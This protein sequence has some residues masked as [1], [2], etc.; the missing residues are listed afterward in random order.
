M[1]VAISYLEETTSKNFSLERLV[2]PIE[3]IDLFSLLKP[4]ED[5]F[6][7]LRFGESGD[8]S[9]LIPNDL[10]GIEL[11]ISP[12]YG[13]LMNFENA[14]LEIGIPSLIVDKTLPQEKQGIKTLECFVDSYSSFEK[15]TITIDDILIKEK[16]LSTKSD[17]MLQMDIEGSEYK[18]LS[19]I[20]EENLKKFRIVSI[21]FHDLPMMRH[22]WNF[23]N[24]YKPA[25]SRMLENH[26]VSAF[27]I[28]QYS[29]MW[30]I[31]K[32]IY[33][34]DTIE[35]T[36]HRKDRLISLNPTRTPTSRPHINTENLETKKFLENILKE[37]RR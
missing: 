25:F 26:Y 13:H 14:L 32:K 5:Q 34:P 24:I 9:Y 29:G 8:G 3:I 15:R 1:N 6:E 33:F 23:E 2:P 28:N 18:V 20:S 30:S 22:R 36:F 17:L 35:V 37:S 7:I 11:C 10:E 12:G 19:N 16:K 31:D 27:S 21:E 4:L